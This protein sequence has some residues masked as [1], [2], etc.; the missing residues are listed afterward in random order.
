MSEPIFYSYRELTRWVCSIYEAIRPLKI[1]SVEGLVR[2]YAQEAL[3]LF[4]DRLVTGEWQQLTN[5]HIDEAAAM[6]HF[7]TVNRNEALA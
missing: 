3:R 7:S 4:Q 5:E 6:L 2:V 1:L